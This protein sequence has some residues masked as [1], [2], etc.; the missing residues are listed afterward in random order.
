MFL[1]V[2]IFQQVNQ[3]EHPG[4]LLC[5]QCS[6]ALPDFE[7]FRT[8]LKSHLEE[9]GG[10]RGLLG[11][12]TDIMG[13][14]SSQDSRVS[15]S[16]SPAA[17]GALACPHCGAKFSGADD[18]QAFEQ[19]VATH[20]L[21]TA[22]EYGCQSCLKLFPKPDELQKHLMDIHAHHLYR[23]SLCKEMFDSKVAIQVSHAIKNII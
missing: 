1:F 12:G 3:Y 17:S 6:A 10:L 4:T 20:F 11:G 18:H 5:N 9:A 15:S 13:M 14:L 23:C 16:K 2:S 8:H 19:H 22:T 21:A 7:S